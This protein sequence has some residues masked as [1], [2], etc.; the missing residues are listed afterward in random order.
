VNGV[1]DG[2]V[3][4]H[5]GMIPRGINRDSGTVARDRIGNR[6]GFP[7]GFWRQAETSNGSEGL[8]VR[9]EA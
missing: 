3:L 1:G 6:Q 9:H 8:G 5:A 7:G 2:L 4:M